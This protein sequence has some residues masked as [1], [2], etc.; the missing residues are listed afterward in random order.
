MAVDQIDVSD[1]MEECID[2][3]FEAVKV[4]EW[5]ADECIGAGDEDLAQCIRLCR[6]V[7]DI[8]ATCARFCSHNPN[9]CLNSPDC[10]QTYVRSALTSASSTT[11]RLRKRALMSSESAP[12]SAVI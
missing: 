7:A 3:C 9:I 6:D 1:D 8:A 5:C 4:C 10:V 2:Q 12:N 11:W